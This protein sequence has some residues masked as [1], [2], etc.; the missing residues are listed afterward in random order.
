MCSTNLK[1]VAAGDIIVVE[2]V[3]LK[4]LGSTF[5]LRTRLMSTG[6]SQAFI[7]FLTSE[8]PSYDRTQVLDQATKP[9]EHTLVRAC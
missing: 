8:S 4:A 7:K 6:L 3:A 5:P 9:E 1:D 2:E